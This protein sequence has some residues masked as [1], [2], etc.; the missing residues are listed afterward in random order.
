MS[1]LRETFLDGLADM[2]DAEKQLIKA[3]PKMLQAAEN[4]SLRAGFE[5]H[6]SETESHIS[7]LEEVFE[8]FGEKPKGKNCK[9]MKGLI[10]EG[11]ELFDDHCRDAAIIVAAQ[12]VEHY[13]IASYGSLKSWAKLLGK[14][15]AA[16]LLD[17]TLREEKATDLKLTQV[18]ESVVNIEENQEEAE[19]FGG[20]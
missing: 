16:G 1:T 4:E 14:R 17:Q 11:E 19:H 20:H 6:L 10:E 18:A 2:Y 15:E 8:I 3:L 7:R 13:E 9:A 12:K 5:T